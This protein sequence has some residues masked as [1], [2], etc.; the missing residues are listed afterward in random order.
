VR[1]NERDRELSLRRERGAIQRIK[2]S[3]QR[4]HATMRPMEQKSCGGLGQLDTSE[5]RVGLQSNNQIIIR[6]VPYVV[7][8]G[9]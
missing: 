6:Q 4:T 5:T 3:A 9:P 8:D 7:N 1:P 2:P